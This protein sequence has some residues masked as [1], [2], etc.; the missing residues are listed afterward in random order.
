[1]R[2]CGSTV[3][4]RGGRDPF[5]NSS[6]FGFLEEN[7]I[8]TKII[9]YTGKSF[10]L[11]DPQPEMVCIED[12]AHS[13]SLLCRY[14]GHAK[15]FYSVA[16]HCVLMAGVKSPS[17]PLHRLLHD[18]GE[19]YI[20]DMSSPWKQILWTGISLKGAIQYVRVKEWEQKIQQAVG[21]ALGVDLRHSTEV[22]DIDNRMY[23]T[24]VRDLMMQSEEFGKWRANLK[25]FDFFITSWN[26]KYAEHSFLCLYEHIKNLD[27]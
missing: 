2:P 17:N 8:N 20:G 10:D 15:E 13:L 26:P 12:I 7:T 4:N 3:E 23:F 14:T 5:R 6:N 16:Q 27:Y 18:A 25:P 24:E 1:M 22:K 11:L 21:V 9:T 19:A